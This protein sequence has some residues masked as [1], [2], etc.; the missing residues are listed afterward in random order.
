MDGEVL[1]PKF[2]ILPDVLKTIKGYNMLQPGDSVVVGVSGG[3]DSTALLHVLWRLRE[4]W[5][6]KLFIAHLNH[7]I[8][9]EDA[10]AD[11]QLV[12]ALG[13][14][15]GIPVHVKE[16][17]IPGIARKTGRSE[18]EAGRIARYQLYEELADAVGASRIAVGHHGDDQV[19]T[20]LMNLIRG[21]GLR[22]LSGIPPV[23]GR[24]IRPLID[25]EKW[26]LEAY[27]R[28][29]DLPWREDVTNWSTAYRRNFVRWEIIPKLK[30]LNPGAVRRIMQTASTLLEDWQLLDQLALEAFGQTVLELRPGRQVSLN[31]AE[32]SVLPAAIRK[33]IAAHAYS[34]VTHG[35]QSLAAA[36]LDYV[37]KCIA[38]EVPA[39][40]RTLPGN[41]DVFVRDEVLILA[42]RVDMEKDRG[43][44]PCLLPLGS[45]T[46]IESAGLSI[47]LQ[48]LT[49]VNPWWEVGSPLQPRDAWQE[50][51][52][53]W[54][55]MD[56]ASLD[57]PLY[58]RSRQPGD[59]FQPLG[60]SG[61]KK[62]K[63]LFI[64]EKIPRELRNKIPCIID[65][66]GIV[67]VVGLHQDQRTRV[68][69]H[70]EKV[71]RITAEKV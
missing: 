32:L 5:N 19:E 38:G 16:L 8:R 58:A 11:A 40:Q 15:L 30:Q 49:T 14:E 43:F 67:A 57:L 18:E 10:A 33:R 29:W 64:D 23:R 50:L 13:A 7:G 1:D 31:L 37:E 25:L 46:I 20:V 27:C 3:I 26:Q 22:G 35:E 71:L 41:I 4:S 68:T 63:D 52:V 12:E 56:L 60:M 45:S 54:A 65:G 36:G 21:A 42:R 69:D 28:S 47:Q 66:K 51:G 59:R 70:T 55:D 34:K 17:D 62:L 24:V 48:I 9:G 53:W 6:L 39:G 2:D 44:G 61:S